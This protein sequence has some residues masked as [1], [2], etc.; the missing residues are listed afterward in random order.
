MNAPDLRAALADLLSGPAGKGVVASYVY[1]SHA[2]GRPHRES[3]LDLGILFRLADFPNRAER[4]EAGL[5]LHAALQP[6]LGAVPLDLVVLNDA[7]PGLA[8]AV[9]TGGDCVYCPD[10][11]AEHAFRRD[12]QLRAADLLPFLRRTAALKREAIRR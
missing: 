7:P 3:D 8:A 11:E 1:G 2:A 5:K 12:S 9:V 6:A 10:P 4:F